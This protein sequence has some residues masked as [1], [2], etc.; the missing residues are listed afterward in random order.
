M[1]H[2]SAMSPLWEALIPLGFI[3]ILFVFGLIVIAMV[4]NDITK[5]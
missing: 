2:H 1:T 4:V 3:G 5:K